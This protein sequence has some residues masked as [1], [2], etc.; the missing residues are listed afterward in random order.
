MTRLSL[1][2]DTKWVNTARS[3]LLYIVCF[4]SALL[5]VL[6][7]PAKTQ[8][9]D[10]KIIG[11]V[12]NYPARALTQI[13]GWGS[14]LNE[15]EVEPEII[16]L[17]GQTVIEGVEE[18]GP[19]LKTKLESTTS[20]LDT[21]TSSY[22]QM[23]SETVLVGL[24]WDTLLVADVTASLDRLIGSLNSTGQLEWL[25]RAWGWSQLDVILSKVNL[26]KINLATAR[27]VVT[28]TGM[29]PVAY[30]QIKSAALNLDAISDLI[31][32]DSDTLRGRSIYSSYL[33]TV[34][35][36]SQWEKLETRLEEMLVSESYTDVEDVSKQVLA[37]NQIT[38]V[39]EQLATDSKNRSLDLLAI[40]DMNRRILAG[41][42]GMV[43]IGV[44]MRENPTR[45]MIMV[46]NPSVLSSQQVKIK[47]YLPGELGLADVMKSDSSLEIKFDDDKK[48]LYV[49]GEL[50]IAASDTL[51]AFIETTDV[52]KLSDLEAEKIG[53]QAQELVQT[54]ASSKD[55]V[56]AVEIKSNIDTG[57]KDI[58]VPQS[59]QS[60]PE[61]R[62]VSYR[63]A[64]LGLGKMQKELAMLQKMTNGEGLVLGL[65]TEF[66]YWRE[67]GVVAA[68]VLMVLIGGIGLSDGPKREPRKARPMYQFSVFSTHVDASDM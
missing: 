31:G 51:Q 60:R 45:V 4:S 32:N 1:L 16:D 64:K 3:L 43:M 34:D 25:T 49:D 17:T 68:G 59:G 2:L 15:K 24:K 10:S 42:R 44:W 13:D 46:T 36:V 50:T 62:I 14:F 26:V 54:L 66:R 35:T 21:L 52:W 33:Q 58:V 11:E 67:L 29:Q 53:M 9:F 37:L 18:N 12:L 41:S 6:L 22:S 39:Q 40:I 7:T 28:T 5:G 23:A 65:K 30:E 57:V 19:D 63:K 47:Y 61:E 55:Y 56:Q 38:K 48:R 8:A 20:A 27:S